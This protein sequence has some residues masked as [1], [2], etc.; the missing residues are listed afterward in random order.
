MDNI[1]LVTD[2]HF[3]D[4]KFVEDGL[5]PKGYEDK[6]LR[7]LQNCRLTSDSLLIDLG[8]VCRENDEE[9]NKKLTS[10]P[11][12]KWLVLGNHDKKSA[13]WYLAH[14]WDWV[15]KTFSLAIFGRIILFS[16][17][18]EPVGSCLR[19]VCDLNI[20][21]HFHNFTQEKIQ[22][23]EPELFK[24]QDENH[25]LISMEKLNYQPITLKR[26][27]ELAKKTVIK[28]D[29]KWRDAL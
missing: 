5:R 22:Q 17:R 8:D 6:I 1:W 28:E 23:F 11:G 19:P 14:G 4:T 12:K 25:Y 16:H 3:G 15:G 21:G 27:V 26:A 2:T 9:W 24:L 13:S 18:P 10:F 29:D 7:G 20:H